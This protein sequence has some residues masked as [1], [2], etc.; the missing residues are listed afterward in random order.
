MVAVRHFG[1]TPIMGIGSCRARVLAKPY[2]FKVVAEPIEKQPRR[3]WQ[4][5]TTSRWGQSR[6]KHFRRKKAKHG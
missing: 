4:S 6:S 5:R 2:H 3:W 1:T